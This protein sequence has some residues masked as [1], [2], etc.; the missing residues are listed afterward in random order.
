LSPVSVIFEALRGKG[1]S[2]VFRIAAEESGCSR[3]P[4]SVWDVYVIYKV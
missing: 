1:F 2:R 3:Q 4:L